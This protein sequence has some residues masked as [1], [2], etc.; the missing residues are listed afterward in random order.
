MPFVDTPSRP[1]LLQVNL[2]TEEREIV[3]T[4]AEREGV[5]LSRFIRGLVA[6]RYAAQSDQ[7]AA[8]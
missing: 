3:R 7:K 1:A 5:N 2:T 6:E 4:L 8:A